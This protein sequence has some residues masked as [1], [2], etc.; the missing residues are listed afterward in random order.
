MIRLFKH[1]VPY[2]VLLLGLIDFVLMTGAS[3]A[4][5]HLRERQ[6]G[7]ASEGIAGHLWSSL[8]FAVTMQTAMVAVGVYG[9]EALRSLRYAGA[10]QLVA[11]SLAAIGL[12]FLDFLVGSQALWR[13]TL[14]YASVLALFLPTISRLLMG[15]VLGAEALRR[16]ILVLGAGRRADRLRELSEREESGFLIAGYIAMTH[17]AP[18]VENAVQRS[19]IANLP[20]HV[21]SVQASEVVL[22]L[23]ERRNSLPLA[24]LLRIKTTGVH[25][26]DFSSFLERE[27]GRVDLDTLNP[28]WLI[29]SDGF[30]SGR[31]ISSAAKRVFDIAASS[32][33]LI[34]SLPLIV[35]FALAVKL[36]SKGP[37]FFRQRRV[38]LYGECFDVIKL[39]SMRSDAEAN[40][41]QWAQADDPRVTRLGRFIRKTRI[42]ELPQTWSVLRGEMSF[43]GPRPERPEF[44]TDL[45]KQLPYYAERHMVKPGITG[46]AQINYPYGASTE[47]SRHKLEYDLYYAKNYT[48]FL[49]LLI[50][51]QTLRV[52][53]WR[54]GAR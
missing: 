25:V 39:R 19:A 32:L 5:W 9:P 45:E 15:K 10:R 11:V 37:A 28:S 20:Q 53:L 54:E 4:A 1:Y 6:I 41:A 38:G 50:L 43:V 18:V 31:A 16:R 33:L 27:T 3:L 17:T 48:P 12:S 40:G 46:W 22:A 2:P 24:D 49:D 51:L 47:D 8:G 52:V 13:S 30:S 29:F 26:N 14:A 36:D 21:V 44:V 34:I 23:E 42:D 7:M 35:V